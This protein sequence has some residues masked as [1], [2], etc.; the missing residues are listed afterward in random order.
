[1]YLQSTCKGVMGLVK[2]NV[3]LCNE[4]SSSVVYSGVVVGVVVVVSSC[5]VVVVVMYCGVV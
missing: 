4:V 5:S 3:E 1:M 2:C